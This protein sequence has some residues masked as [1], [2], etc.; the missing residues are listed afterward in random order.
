VQDEF[1]RA[2]PGL[3]KVR[4]VRHGY[5][6]EYD[7]VDPRELT[8]TL[9][10]RR[11]PGLFLAGQINGTTGYEEAAGQGLI[12]GFNAALKSCNFEIF[13]LDRTQSYIGVMIDDLV[14]RGTNEPYRMFTSRAEYRLSLRAD[15]ADQRLTPLGMAIGCIGEERAEAFTQKMEALESARS[16]V[17]EWEATPHELKEK[18]IEVN[19]DGVRRSVL[20][21]LAYPDMSLERLAQIWPAI[22]A[23]AE[24]IATQVEI[25]GKYRSYLER[26]EADI[27]A[28]KKDEALLLP[29]DFNFDGVG[30]LSAEVRQK[31][32]AAQPAT[33]GAAARIPGITPAALAA[34]LRFV[35]RK[36]AR[37]AA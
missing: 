22:S 18:G 25:D 16:L 14:T 1:V 31:L 33:L 26:Q 11:A 36:P 15:N 37:K 28:F 27:R 21:L 5:A 7:F 32:K 34:L 29:P 9:E 19:Q 30:S 35:K 6:I 12:A 17:R 24:D 10:T 13:T 3:E 8:H 4:F 23:F 2:I 20:D